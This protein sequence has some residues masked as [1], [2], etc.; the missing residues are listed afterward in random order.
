MSLFSRA[1]RVG[2]ARV[3]E[4]EGI[5]GRPFTA[6]DP[7]V[8]QENMMLVARGEYKIAKADNESTLRA[9]GHRQNDCYE[10]KTLV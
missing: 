3:A 8:T 7:E 2:D 10:L 6:G 4:L 1:G 9:V 5:G